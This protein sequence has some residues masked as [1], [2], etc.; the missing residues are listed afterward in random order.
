M[1]WVKRDWLNRGNVL[2][3]FQ[4]MEAVHA[5]CV[6]VSVGSWREGKVTLKR[7]VAPKK[8]AAPKKKTAFK[9]P[10][11]FKKPTAIKKRKEKA[12]DPTLKLKV[13]I[14]S[15]L[16]PSSPFKIADEFIE[17]FSGINNIS[18]FNNEDK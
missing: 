12:R 16:L 17:I 8:K 7:R 2:F 14:N 13:E 10:I 6:G 1:N 9:K 5:L 11:I 15:N 3:Q 18:D 4:S